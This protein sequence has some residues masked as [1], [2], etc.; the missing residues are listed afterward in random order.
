MTRKTHRLTVLG[1]SGVGKTTISGILS[2]AGW[3]DYSCDYHIGSNYL[4]NEIITDLISRFTCD[5]QIKP[6]IDN[7]TLEIHGRITNDNLHLLSRF[8][9]KIGNPEQEGLDYNEFRRRQNLY[10]MAE[11]EVVQNVSGALP[12]DPQIPFIHDSSGSLCELPEFLIKELAKSTRLVYIE[13]T[14]EDEELLLERARVYPKPLYYPPD[15]LDQALT[16]YMK[17]NALHYIALIDPDDFCRWVFPKLFYKR[18]P[19]YKE[20]VDRYEGVT[21]SS[22][23]VKNI[24]SEQDFLELISRDQGSE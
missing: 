8:V 4:K 17:E 24:K 19:Q 20:M 10:H 9:G 11:Q 5:P 18:L 12:D 13:A 7:G 2:D 21:I 22:Q 3:V 16:D 14:K 1:M 15:F 23:D 6:L